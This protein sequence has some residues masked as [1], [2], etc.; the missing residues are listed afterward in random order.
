M[1]AKKLI[2]CIYLYQAKAVAGMTE[3]DRVI[4][5]NPVELAKFYSD[6]GADA[7]LVFDFSNTDKEHDISTGILKEIC[8]V[9]EVPVYAGGNI[10]RMEDVK[11]ILYAGAAKAFLNYSKEGNIQLTKEVSDKFGKEKIAAMI[12]DAG[13]ITAWDQIGLYILLEESNTDQVA[14]QL[15]RSFLVISKTDQVQNLENLLKSDFILGVAGTYLSDVNNNLMELKASMEEKG[16]SMNGLKTSIAFSLLKLNPDGLIPVIVQDY[17]TNEVLMLAYM[18]E[19]S[20]SQTLRLGRMTYYSRSRQELW[21][22]GETSG[23]YQYVKEISHD[24]DKDTLLAKVSQTGAACHTGNYSCFYSQL[25]KTEYNHTDP[26]KVLNNVYHTIMDRK[27]NPKEGSYTNYLFEKGIDKILKKVGEE[28]TEIVIAAKNPDPE[29][30]KYEIADFLY[31]TMV[32]MAEQGVTWD[33][34]MRELADRH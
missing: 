17:K 7:I 28:A 25:T 18:N 22:K 3:K 14:E 9:S 20:F 1:E 4:H 27:L 16:I 21:L 13:E 19:E 2:P 10:K 24:C 15:D 26:N 33:D 30:I 31:H 12:R 32:L 23:H 6:Q 34:I 8:R 29:E 5:E 11:K